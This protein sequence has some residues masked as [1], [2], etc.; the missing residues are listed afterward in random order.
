M[1]ADYLTKHDGSHMTLLL[2]ENIQAGKW[3]DTDEASVGMVWWPEPAE[4]RGMNECVD[5]GDSPGEIR[6]ARPSSNHGGGVIAAFCD[7]HVQFVREDIDYRV[8]QQLMTP[9]SEEA[10]LPGVLESED[11]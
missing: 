1:S 5:V 3:T 11:F 7:G 8:Y 9:N 10:G 2:S 4:C 6:Y